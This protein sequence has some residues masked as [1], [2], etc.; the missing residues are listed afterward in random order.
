MASGSIGVTSS[1]QYIVGSLS[2]S[3]IP[4]TAGNYSNVY[5]ELR[6][7]RNNTGYTTYG[8]GTWSITINGSTSS[9]TKAV[10]LT[11]N[12]NTFI[13][14]YSLRVNHND[15]GTK[16]IRISCSG[17]ISDTSYSATYGS[18][19]ITLNTIPRASQPTV[20][21]SPCSIG[22]TLTILSHRASTSF[23][24]KFYYAFG[25]IGKTP[26]KTYG[27]APYDND[28]T[29]VLPN[30]LANQIPSGTSGTGTIYCETYN[31]STLIG[32]KTVS[33]KATVPNTN[34]FRPT[35]SSVAVA[36]T[37]SGVT[38]LSLG[39]YVQSL[40]NVKF[41][42]SGIAG[43]YG[44]T[45]STV[46][47]TFNGTTYTASVSSG[48]ATWTTGV[49]ATSGTLS[50]SITATDSR[51]YSLTTA[52]TGSITVL[53]YT[54]PIIS[55]FSAKRCDVNGNLNEIGTYLK[56]TRDGSAS[57][58]KDTA[59]AEKNTLTCTVQWSLKGA[60]SWTTMAEYTVDAS[61]TLSISTSVTNSTKS[62]FAI[63]SAYDIKFTL[64]D[65]FNNTVSTQVVTVGT[66]MMSWGKSG[67]G[68]GKVISSSSNFALE[69]G[70]NILIDGGRGIFSGY[71]NA[72]ILNDHN[73]GNVTLSA[74]G[75]ELFLGYVNTSKVRVST[76]LYSS[77]G[78]KALLDGST[79]ALTNISALNNLSIGAVSGSW[80]NSVP[81]IAGDGGMK[82]GKYIDF[83][84]TST[85][86]AY[87]ARL[88]SSGGVLKASGGF[89]NV[90]K[91][92]AFTWSGTVGYNTSVT[93]T[94]NLGYVPIIMLSGS[95]GNMQ[96][97]TCN[98]TD[99][100]N[101]LVLNNYSSGDN[102]W[103]GIVYFW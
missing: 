5:V 9:V 8:T 17:G 23:T 44:S 54:A 41:T 56:I 28:A 37:V 30:S 63:T 65:K 55:S 77:D 58:L 18:G 81:T 75:G 19:T 61:S 1:N 62:D 7:W 89:G 98:K 80:F 36:D 50:Y 10:T 25:S 101:Q 46:K 33:F 48:T 59:S 74:P 53:P 2:W 29:W 69:V 90:G 103:T 13:H 4:N 79:R 67:V 57:S 88:T 94:H 51:G 6:M 97:T 68:I 78:S 12:S 21:P 73:N 71:N 91:K 38:S 70:G 64:T 15:D 22:S 40:S 83:H 49:L 39:K 31:G 85:T 11:Y 66:V 26:I 92:P 76:P 45:V 82:I 99:N 34:T 87:N 3:S 72:Y 35:I 42:I 93:I 16:A 86:S 95:C 102:I 24:H 47:V 60:N 43:A 14:S 32:T 52:K 27:S 20:S 100:I 84:E 96:M